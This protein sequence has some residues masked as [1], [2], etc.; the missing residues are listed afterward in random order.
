MAED[1]KVTEEVKTESDV[2]R[3]PRGQDSREAEMNTMDWENP[4]N[5]PAPTPQPG[6]VFRWVRTALLG[7]ADN[8]NVS[9]KFREGWIPCKSEDHPEL[10]ILMDHKSEWATK[11]NIEVGGQILCKIPEE[12]AKARDE[13]FA[14]QAKNQIES[15]DN[16]YFKDNDPR[17]KKEVYERKSRTSFGSDS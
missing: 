6:W 7:E 1:K 2:V 10:S 5:L 15:V 8:P 14:G 11:G 12:K 17:M 9:R 3:T 16:A 13:Y 4:V